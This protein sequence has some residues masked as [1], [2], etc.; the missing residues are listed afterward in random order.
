MPLKPYASKS[1]SPTPDIVKIE[2]ASLEPAVLRNIRIDTSP[3]RASVENGPKAPTAAVG[4]KDNKEAVKPQ[5]PATSR[6]RDKSVQR[7]KTTASKEKSIPR[8]KPVV[9]APAKKLDTLED[10]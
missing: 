7:E 1:K 6:S 8:D 4:K 3:Q 9:K 10:F 2:P 5:L